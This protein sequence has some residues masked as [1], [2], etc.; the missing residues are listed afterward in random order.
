LCWPLSFSLWCGTC[1]SDEHTSSGQ[2]IYLFLPSQFI[3][4][5][6]A[7]REKELPFGHGDGFAKVPRGQIV[8]SRGRKQSAISL[9][10]CKD[11]F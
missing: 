10:T 11:T 8:L 4:N 7:E 6:R 5:A 9:S 3:R 1:V 2:R